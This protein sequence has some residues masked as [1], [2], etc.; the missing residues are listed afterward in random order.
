[1]IF[2]DHTKELIRL[3][4]EGDKNARDKLVSENMGLVYSAARRFTARGCEAEDIVQVGVIGLIKGIDRFDLNINVQFSTYAVAMIIGEIKR[5][6]RDDGMIKVSRSIKENSFH[7]QKAVKD[8][9]LKLHREPSI[10]EISAQTGI[11]AEDIAV[12]QDA[13]REVDSIHRPVV[14]SDGN[15]MSL[16]EK[17]VGREDESENVINSIVCRRLMD[18]LSGREKEIISLRYFESK[19]QTEIASNM[20]ISQVQVSRIEKK[21]LLGFRKQLLEI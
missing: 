18:S 16:E 4:K 20:G 10:E 17:L 5:Y 3:A 19:T 6:I 13:M 12:A 1:M 21:V 8:L 7:I 15:E 9:Q 2:M 14:N 11:L